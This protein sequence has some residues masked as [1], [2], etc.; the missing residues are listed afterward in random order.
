M[1]EDPLAHAL[2][3]FSGRIGAPQRAVWQLRPPLPPQSDVSPRVPAPVADFPQPLSLSSALT[4]AQRRLFGVLFAHCSHEKQER[5]IE[6]LTAALASDAAK[7][8]K[9]GKKVTAPLRVPCICVCALL[10]LAAVARAQKAAPSR[11]QPLADAAKD[12][13]LALLATGPGA[14]RAGALIRAADM[15]SIRVAVQV[16]SDCAIRAFSPSS[17]LRY[18]RCLFGNIACHGMSTISP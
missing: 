6:M 7:A 8:P 15:S 11:C 18:A 14:V 2:V 12:L 3:T 13:G 5:L 1:A 17:F 10:G 4:F 16:M 9:G